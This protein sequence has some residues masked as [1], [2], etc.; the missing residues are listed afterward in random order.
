[1]IRF[2]C[3]LCALLVIAGGRFYQAVHLSHLTEPEA[4]CR[5]WVV[6]LFSIILV[7]ISVALEFSEQN[8]E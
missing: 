6:W 8:D 3:F 7:A 2:S 1:M 4:F 5:M